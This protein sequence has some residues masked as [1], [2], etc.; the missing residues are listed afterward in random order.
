[1][2]AYARAPLATV[3]LSVR[4]IDSQTTREGLCRCSWPVDRVRAGED[5]ENAHSCGGRPDG[6]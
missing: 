4:G 6:L 2:N 1:M 5:G 3:R